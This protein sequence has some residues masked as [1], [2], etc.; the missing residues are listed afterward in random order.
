M[1]EDP[2]Q[3]ESVKDQPASP[4]LEITAEEL[5][6]EDADSVTGGGGTMHMGMAP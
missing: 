4:D 5:E 1:P 3:E 6:S 2:K